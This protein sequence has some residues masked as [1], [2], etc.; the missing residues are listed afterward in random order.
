MW[1]GL[2]WL[3]IGAVKGSYKGGN[4]ILVSIK[5]R[6]TLEWLRKG[7]PLYEGSAPSVT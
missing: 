6:E 1:A 2:I 7:R 5:Y 4:E 3:R